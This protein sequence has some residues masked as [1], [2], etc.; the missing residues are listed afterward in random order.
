MF[1]RG[2][3]AWVKFI[4][5]ST[6]RFTKNSRQYEN[7]PWECESLLEIANAALPRGIA[8][9]VTDIRNTSSFVANLT[10]CR[11]Y[12][13][14][15]T[16]KLARYY[17]CTLFSRYT[18]LCIILRMYSTNRCSSA[19]IKYIPPRRRFVHAI[20]RSNRPTDRPTDRPNIHH[21]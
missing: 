11:I 15:V 16:P 3:R 17:C 7:F 6:A 10:V 12:T 19:L 5:I 21:L 2:M 8:T 18:V 4:R 9:L 14:M 13:H 1:S 20:L